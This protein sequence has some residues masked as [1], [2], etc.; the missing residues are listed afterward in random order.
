VT[1]GAD[2]DQGSRA[3]VSVYLCPASGR[4]ARVWWERVAAAGAVEEGLTLGGVFA[5]P[6]AETPP[7]RR[8]GLVTLVERLDQDGGDVVVPSDDDLPGDR[9]AWL[10][11]APLWG[12][13]FDS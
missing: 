11:L 1:R 4:A 3:Q 13:D 2:D 10:E 9:D 6:D 5:D 8:A 12:E 7:E